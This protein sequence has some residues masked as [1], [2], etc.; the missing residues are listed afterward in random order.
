MGKK[1]GLFWFSLMTAA[2]GGAIYAGNRLYDMAIKPRQHKEEDDKSP[3]IT[4]GRLW[5][6][7]H[8]QRRDIYIDSIDSLRLHAVY[9]PGSADEHRVVILIHGIW[10]SSDGMGIYAR[11]YHKKGWNILL[12][13]LRGFGRSEGNYAGYGWDDR[14]DIIEWIYWV[15]KRDPDA[16]ILLHGTSMG[17]ATTLMVTGEH[18]PENVIC[19]I[20]DSSYTTVKD[21]FTNVWK[22]MPG[23]T[24][25]VWM[26]L[27]VLR[28]K[29]R[30]KTGFDFY[31]IRPV[32]AVTRSVTPTLFIHGSG[33]KFVDPAMCRKLYDNAA[34]QKEYCMVMDT[35]HIHAVYDAPDKYWSRIDEFL[36]HTG[37]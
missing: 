25:P 16:R 15:I 31:K 12:P 5:V 36:L 6:R 2:A 35:D 24:I 8:P 20:S 32:D 9:I 37:F 13:D 11:E 4:Q 10:D 27:S 17:A 23:R 7:N 22:A 19:A 21:Q 14:Y 26:A 34:C 33:D 30:L 29:T 3:R 28:F 18:L 1:S